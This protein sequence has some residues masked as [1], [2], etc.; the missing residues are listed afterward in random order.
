MPTRS[1]TLRRLPATTRKYYRLCDELESVLTRLKN[2]RPVIQDLELVARAEAA[3]ELHQ[4]SVES[5]REVFDT[6]ISTPGTG[7]GRMP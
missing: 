7:E 3:R 5:A 6:S 4:A 1:A 2:F